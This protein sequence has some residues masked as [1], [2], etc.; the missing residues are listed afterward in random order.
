[1]RKF[2]Y[3]LGFALGLQKRARIPIVPLGDRLKA[4]P[5]YDKN[6]KKQVAKNKGVKELK[7]QRAVNQAASKMP[8]KSNKEWPWQKHPDWNI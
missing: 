5:K 7:F 6:I 1:M 4:T 2:A 8:P 3:D